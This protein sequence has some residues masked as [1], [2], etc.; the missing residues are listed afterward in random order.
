MKACMVA[1]TFYEGDNRV[2]RYAE[3]L[4]NQGWHVDAIALQYK[5]TPAFEIIK[6]V[7]VHRVQKRTLNEKRKINYLLRLLM[8][9][10][11]SMFFL[12][13]NSFQGKYD[14]IHVHSVPDFEI[15]AA[16]FQKL[17]GSKL[18][19]DIHDLVPE[20]FTSKFNSKKDSFLFNL[21]VFVEKLSCTFANHVIIANDIWGKRLVQRS[22]P[23]NKCTVIMNYP[24]LNIFKNQNAAK[25]KNKFLLVYPGSLNKHQGIETAIRAVSILKDK[26]PSIHFSIYGSGTDEN[27]FKCIV[28]ELQLGDVVSF[29]GVI[30]I[31]KVPEVMAKADVGVEP[32]LANGFSD[33]AFS[34]KILEFMT[35]NIP[36]VVSS[37]SVHQYYI[38]DSL[39][40]YHEPGNVNDLADKILQLYNNKELREQLVL[41][42]SRFIKDFTWNEK[43]EIYLNL[44]KKIVTL[45]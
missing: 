10:F 38:D 17:F 41:K 8:F 44:I 40:L 16:V 30:S 20:L 21:L 1:Y 39:V 43:N 19:L 35:L 25:E 23:K 34:T 32:K 3:T 11:S 37:T 2:R 36:L 6:G 18:I 4:V 12:C 5:N 29:H 15:F 9:F 45:K 22:V 24:D 31:E 14:V 33:E 42:S 7:N 28:R 13:K 26:I 27:Y